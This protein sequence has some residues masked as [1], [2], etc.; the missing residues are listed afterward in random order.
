MA[1]TARTGAV[2]AQAIW[3]AGATGNVTQVR[4]PEAPRGVLTAGFVPDSGSIAYA[5][6]DNTYLLTIDGQRRQ[7]IAPNGREGNTFIR[8]SRDG[9]RLVYASMQKQNAYNAGE[10]W[11]ATTD[12]SD[13][14]KLTLSGAQDF[15][16]IWTGDSRRIVYVHR[17]NTEQP[18]ADIE[19]ALLVSNLWVIDLQTRT[20]RPLTTFKGKRVRQPSISTD[21]QRI[22]FICNC[23]GSDDVWVT[24]FFGGDPYSLTNDKASASFP[25]WLW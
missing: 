1:C 24:D 10:L 22:T 20:Q 16:P 2:T 17:E 18:A 5:D 4:I 12:G 13:P 19:P 25:M 15:D 11:L 8:F 6:F 14:Q 9:R 23:N 21:D 7:E 3:I